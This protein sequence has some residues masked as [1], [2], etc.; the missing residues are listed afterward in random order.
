MDVNE[1]KKLRSILFRH[2][3]GIAIIPTVHGLNEI[4][5]ID[6][7]K[8][9]HDFSFTDLQSNFKTNDGYLNVALRLLASQGWLNRNI[10]IDGQEIDFSLTKKG[11]AML[12]FSNEYS[13]CAN[14]LQDLMIIEKHLLDFD[15]TLEKIAVAKNLLVKG[16]EPN[17]E[18]AARVIVKLYQEGKI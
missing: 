6:F 4:G 5:I 2:L 17:T 8:E 9:H 12:E 16:G 18:R 7:I 13:A 15:E 14:H 10:M 11:K 1:K 3:D